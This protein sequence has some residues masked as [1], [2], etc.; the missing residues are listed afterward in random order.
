MWAKPTRNTAYVAAQHRPC[1]I[2]EVR[3]AFM[4][5]YNTPMMTPQTYF[6]VA[7]TIAGSDSGGGAGIQADLRAFRAFHVH[8]C[9]VITALTAQNPHGVRSIQPTT[10]EVLRDQMR[11]IAEDFAVKAIKTGMLL[12]A[13]RIRIVAE[14]LPLFNDVALVVDPVMVATSGAKLLA[15]EAIARFTDAILPKATLITPNLP[16]ANVLLGL[17]VAENVRDLAAH[18]RNLAT[19]YAVAVLLKGG[20]SDRHVATDFFADTA[21]NCFEITSPIVEN[22]PTTHGTGCSLSAAIAANLALNLPLLEA[23]CRAKAWVYALLCAGVSAGDAAVYG[24][25]SA[26]PPRDC[27]QVRNLT[28]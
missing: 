4:I 20:H 2:K 13:E 12:D 6:P 10:P 16:E 8:G 15:G 9:S 1:S 17:P 24:T 26:E 19:R 28:A 3:H 22:P 5:C 23:V 25:E 18:C 27:I 11:C 7:L 14:M 21:G